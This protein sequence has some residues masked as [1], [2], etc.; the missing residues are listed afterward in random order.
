VTV[1]VGNAPDSRDVWFPDDPRQ[2]P[3]PPF[4][5]EVVAA[6]LSGVTC[7][8]ERDEER[9]CGHWGGRRPACPRAPD[10]PAAGGRR[11]RRPDARQVR[12]VPGARLRAAACRAQRQSKVDQARRLAGPFNS[13]DPVT[14]IEKRARTRPEAGSPSVS[15]TDIRTCPGRSLASFTS[16]TPSSTGYAYGGLAQPGTLAKIWSASVLSASPMSKP[17]ASMSITTL[18]LAAMARSLL[19][20]G[21]LPCSEF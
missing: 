18:A 2:T 15:L 20:P 21:R 14:V 1:R 12:G 10:R 19:K 7:E 6:P 16:C 13:C 11:H 8:R 3:Y 4:L 5:D 9:T 17:C